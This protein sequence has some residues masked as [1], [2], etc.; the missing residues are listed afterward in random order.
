MDPSYSILLEA[1]RLCHSGVALKCYAE[2]GGTPRFFRPAPGTVVLGNSQPGDVRG[3]VHHLGRSFLQEQHENEI[4]CDT[5]HVLSLSL[6]V[7]PPPPSL[8][9][10][11]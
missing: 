3:L 7:A 6:S 1:R 10:S 2:L 11:L 8:S 9:I 4:I 5:Y